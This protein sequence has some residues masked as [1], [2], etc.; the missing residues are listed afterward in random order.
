VC[1]TRL[2][3]GVNCCTHSYENINENSFRTTPSWMGKE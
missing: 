2:H 3:Q 1:G